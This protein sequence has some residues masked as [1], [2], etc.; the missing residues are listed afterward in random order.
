[1]RPQPRLTSRVNI[2]PACRLRRRLCVHRR[3]ARAARR[4]K[5][6]RG[7]HPGQRQYHL[8]ALDV[9]RSLT[10]GR[11]V[12]RTRVC[13]ERQL[14]R[15]RRELLSGRVQPRHREPVHRAGVRHLRAFSSS[16]FY[17]QRPR[18]NFDFAHLRISKASRSPCR[19]LLRGAWQRRARTSTVGAR[20]RTRPAISLAVAPTTL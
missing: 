7:H 16:R 14:R 6:L 3:T 15:V 4:R 1:M 8:H 11:A 13:P 10:H 19:S 12:G 5:D 17:H 20:M 9:A 2:K 18:S